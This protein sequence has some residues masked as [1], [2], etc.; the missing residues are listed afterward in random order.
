MQHSFAEAVADVSVA[1]AEAGETP[2]VYITPHFLSQQI[3]GAFAQGCEGKIVQLP[4]GMGENDYDF[5]KATKNL[6]KQGFV[7]TGPMATYGI[8]RGCGELIRSAE[9][10]KHDYWHIDNGYVRQSHHGRLDA[11]GN[12]NPDL[13]GYYRITKNGFQATEERDCPPDRWEEAKVPIAPKWN[14]GRDILVIPPSRFSAQY[15][16]IDPEAWLAQV[17]LEIKKRT[18]RPIRV[19]MFKGGMKDYWP[20][21]HCVVTHE[22]MAGLHALIAGVPAISLGS[23]C[24]GDLSWKWENLEY[25]DYFDRGR[26]H[27]LCHWLA[28]NQ[29]TL[30]EIK[31]GKAWGMLNDR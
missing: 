22:S 20:T 21:T 15:Q 9:L 17:D 25:P 16:R 5:A 13:S 12:P 23:H 18:D 6:M 31:S 2:T 29:W 8:L 27:K 4:Y 1:V 30:S 28:Y 19:K 10:M 26:V 3:A 11:S 14:E 7:V 24:I